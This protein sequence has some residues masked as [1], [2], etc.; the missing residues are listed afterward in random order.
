MR[1]FFERVAGIALLV[2]VALVWAQPGA[3]R[4]KEGDPEYGDLQELQRE[5]QVGAFAPQPGQRVQRPADIPDIFGPGAVLSAGRVF[6]K[7]T[8][9]GLDGNPFTAVSSDPSG[10]WPGASGVEYLNF[11]AIAVGAKNPLATDPT[12]VHRVSY[13]TEWRPPTLDTRDRMYRSFEGEVHGERFINDDG[14]KDVISGEPLIDEDRLDGRDNDGDGLV[15][16]DFAAIGQQMYTGVMRDDTPEAVAAATAEKHVPLGL[17]LFKSDWAYSVAGYQDFDVIQYDIYNRSGHQLDSVFIGFRT[18]MDCGPIDKS[19]YWADDYHLPF[20][21][22][23]D[24]LFKVDPSMDGRYQS[25][26]RDGLGGVASGQ[27]LCPAYKIHIQGWSCVDD[28]GDGARTPGVATV[29]L[30]GYSLDQSYGDITAYPPAGIKG[31]TDIRLRAFR[32]FLSGT[33]FADGGAPT[34]DAQRYQFMAGNDGVDPKTHFVNPPPDPVPTKGD[35]SEWTS[36]GPWLRLADGEHLQATIAF[37]VATGTNGLGN[38]YMADYSSKVDATQKPPAVTDA[39]KIAA[40]REKY[41]TLDVALTAQIAYEG[42]YEVNRSDWPSTW[43]TDDHGREVPL[44]APKG[45]KRFYQQGCATHDLEPREVNDS[46]YTWFDFD[47]DYCTGAFSPGSGGLFHRTWVAAS[48]PP[49]PATNT[50]AA[51]NYTDNPNRLQRFIP[52]GDGQVT[53]AWDNLS[54][55]TPNPKNGRFDFRGYKVWKVSNWM[56]PVGSSG[57]QA[58]D[59]TL[60]AEYRL[61]SSAPTNGHKI[62]CPPESIGPGRPCAANGDSLLVGPSTF[63]PQKNAY[64]PLLLHSGELWNGQTGEVLRPDETVGCIKDPKDPRGGCLEVAGDSLCTTIIPVSHIS[65]PVGRWHIVDRQVKNGFLY[66][67]SVTAFGAPDAVGGLPELESSSAAVEA[68]GVVPQKSVDLV[69]S[70]SHVWVVPNP[71]RGGTI[72]TRPSSWDLIPNASDPTGT[73]VDFLGLP[74]GDWRI[75]IFTVS[76]DLVVELGARDAVNESIRPAITDSLGTTRAGSNRQADN[77]NDGQARWNLI[78]RNGQ[79]VVSGIYLFTVELG[80]AV[81]HR[82]KFVIIR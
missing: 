22:Q 40:L 39:S 9:Y 18:D 23:G 73:H 76:G 27:P 67:Y 70:G 30:L 20:Y 25:A 64:E 35:Y 68:D 55:T 10:Q 1:R 78:S 65:Y 53:I 4:V 72:S 28:D 29:L 19:G 57:P 50:S 12:A 56:R 2:G 37:L 52:A 14:D 36:V 49:S 5:W 16:E 17:E 58:K 21:P 82:G 81:K 60:L 34:I 59:W 11:I 79:D 74:R 63:I 61:F 41:P 38:G 51:Y 69:S 46:K 31:P 80:G 44:I 48:P 15:D 54:E 43:L 71:Y 66:F 45:T 32:S 47:C 24:F 26:H 7:C 6:M 8:N 42:V 33:S 13:S 75:K 62:L 3:A 77:L